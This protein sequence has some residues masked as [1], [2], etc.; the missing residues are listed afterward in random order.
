[1]KR[2]LL[3]VPLMALFLTFG[4]H[5]AQATEGA[6]S[7]YFPGSS[8]T[9]GVAEPPEPGFMA[10]NQLLYFNGNASAAVLRGHV[11]LELKSS[12][13]YNYLAGFYAFKKPVFG[14]RLQIGAAAPAG[15]VT[16]NASADSTL[17]TGNIAENSNGFGDSLVTAALYWK[18]GAV[19]YKLI[20]TV[21]VPSGSYTAGSP[22]N[23]G[24]NYW[25]F[26]TSLGMTWMNKKGT[27]ISIT[28]GILFNTKNNSTDY[29]S[30]NEFHVDVAVN[31]FLAK[32]F[33]V[34]LHGYYYGQLS[35]DSGS[36][37]RLGAFRG[38]SLGFGPAILWMPKA[39]KGNLSV[40]AKW[41]HDVDDKNRMHG[42]YG[43]VVI[44][45]K[46]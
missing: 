31:Q 28:P 33:A 20:Q 21:F 45:Y 14:G 46:F 15:F 42:D 18:K 41:L 38:R 37:A 4:A 39:G 8:T 12:A 11:H 25:A 9:F 44:G 23:V 16:V 17:G 35:D 24:R 19:H 32:N 36:G 1:M 7:Y 26:D 43:Q 30:G 13:V 40:I 6:S 10:A 3:F 2:I 34:G 29:Q 5:T 22:A 27:E